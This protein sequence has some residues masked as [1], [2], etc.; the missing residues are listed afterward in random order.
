ML[1][2]SSQQD[3]TQLLQR[4]N[5]AVVVTSSLLRCGV[6][7]GPGPAHDSGWALVNVHTQTVGQEHIGADV[8]VHDVA[9]QGHGECLQAPAG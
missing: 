7:C 9:D 6:L 8:A 3:R 2:P 5:L 4:S 1:C